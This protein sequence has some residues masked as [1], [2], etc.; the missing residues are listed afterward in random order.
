MDGGVARLDHRLDRRDDPGD[1]GQVGRA[2]GLADLPGLEAAALLEEAG[3]KILQSGVAPEGRH[4]GP[5]L[6]DLGPAAGRRGG[7]FGQRPNACDETIELGHG[8]GPQ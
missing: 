8:V 6:G 3:E 4:S 1:V 2:V 7:V 5:G